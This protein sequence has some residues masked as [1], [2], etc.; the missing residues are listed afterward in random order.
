M[1][2]PPAVGCGVVA[3]PGPPFGPGFPCPLGVGW[4]FVRGPPPGRSPLVR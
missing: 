3:V 1:A 2:A 4:A